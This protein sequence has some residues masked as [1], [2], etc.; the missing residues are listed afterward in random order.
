M[1][2]KKRSVSNP[3]EDPEQLSS[4]I[5]LVEQYFQRYKRRIV[6]VG[7]VIAGLVLAYFGYRYYQDSQNKE[8][9]R[10]LFQAEYH[11][12]ADSLR[13]A[14]H[15]DGVNYG[16]LQIIEQYGGT[17]AA[18]LARFY[19]AVCY[20]KLGQY[21]EAVSHLEDFSNSDWLIQARTYALLGDA[22]MEQEKYE[23]AAEYYEEA[24]SHKPNK[25]FSPYYLRKA[26]LAYER[27]QQI[28]K[29]R[30]CYLR[31][32]EEHAGS[33]LDKEAKKYFYRLD[34]ADTASP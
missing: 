3:L 14:L 2:K 8:A 13:L 7:I 1:S 5:S 22:Y 21:P 12:E 9:Q 32:I 27:M 10:E 31:I 25:Q 34:K 6:Q 19:A 17:K 33:T 28:E 18:N 29:A 4:H 23:E 24:A 30:S 16:F 15:G 20:L 26:A 11:F